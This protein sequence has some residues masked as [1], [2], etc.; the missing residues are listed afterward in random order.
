MGKGKSY[1]VAVIDYGMGNLHS[2]EKALKQVSPQSSIYVGSDAELILSAGRV[3][4]PGVGAIRDC[5]GEVKRLG[6]DDVI[7]EASRRV[8]M[9]GICVGMQGLMRRSA[10]NDGIDCLGVFDYGVE[11]FADHFKVNEEF[12][13]LK[14]P[15]MGWNAVKQIPHKLWDGIFDH[16]HFY[17]VHSYFVPASDCKDALGVVNHGVDAVAAIGRD[18]VFATQFHP[19]K[20]HVDGLR[21]LKNF[22]LWDGS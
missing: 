13:S 21:L 9:L 7:Q 10:E 11:F 8:P 4:Y 22:V 15:H 19:E 2:V 5:I 1:D 3:V 14:V 6:L 20:S 16:S 12:D 17:F 18:N